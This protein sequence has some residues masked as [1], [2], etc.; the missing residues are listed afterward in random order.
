M[1]KSVAAILPV[2]LAAACGGDDAAPVENPQDVRT[3]AKNACGGERPLAFL[4]RPAS[5]GDPCGACGAGALVCATPDMLVCIGN[6]DASCADGGTTNLCGGREPLRLEGMPATPG[7]PCGPCRDGTTIC[8]APEIVAC[9]GAKSAAACRDAGNDVAIADTVTTDV[10]VA[11]TAITDSSRDVSSDAIADAGAEDSTPANACGGYGPLRYQGMDAAPGGRCGACREG[12][13]VCDTPNTL[14]CTGQSTR[15]VCDEDASARNACGGIGPLTWRGVPAE[16]NALCGPCSRY[17]S[18]ASPTTLVCSG[19]SECPDGG[20]IDRCDIPV[21]AYTM[22]RPSWPAP[23]AETA[24]TTTTATTVPLYASWL[25]YNP[26]DFRLYASVAS[27]QG[28]GAN[29]IAVIDPYTASIVSTIFVGTDPRAMALSDDGQVLWVALNGAGTVRQVD[30]VTGTAGQQFSLGED[31]FSRAWF[32]E[33]LAV[34]PGTHGSVVVTRNQKSSSASDGPIVYDDGVARPFSTGTFAVTPGFLIP[35]YSPALIFGYNNHST[36]Y[37]LTAACVN[38][39]GLF[40]KQVTKPFSGFS[41]S[42]AFADNVIYAGFGGVAYDIATSSTIGTFAGRGSVAPDAPKRRVYFAPRPTQGTMVS[43]SAYDMDT[44][45]PQGSETVPVTLS[46]G[47]TPD[48][49]VR[50]GRYGYAFRVANTQLI[51]IARSAL[52]AATP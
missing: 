41:S 46:S 48:N 21:S 45:L 49:F 29:S 50:W 4:S 44:F 14:A 34:L 11:D 20:A 16:R 25:V 24:P 23:P 18:C 37:D 2:V 42:F 43:V 22:P 40:I 7:Q 31:G 38:A 51:V 3:D 36:G 12:T 52:V 17:L 15:D 19:P 32:A 39:S 9:V 8:A 1:G 6:S 10:A 27:T 28:T 47:A 33:S 5:P 26:F 35:T 30:L 13:L